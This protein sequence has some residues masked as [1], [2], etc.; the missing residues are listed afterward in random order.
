[1]TLPDEGRDITTEEW[2]EYDFGGRVYRIE[3]PVRVFIGATTH[4]VVDSAGITH[5]VPK[6]GLEGCAIR[7][8]ANPP[9]SF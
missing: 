2:R 1:M 7:W 4:R 9:V 3:K 8:K 5:C 6:P